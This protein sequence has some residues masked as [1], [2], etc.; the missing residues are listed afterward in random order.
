MQ[1]ARKEELMSL[2]REVLDEVDTALRDAIGGAVGA[3][4]RSN[5]RK[6]AEP[7]R[8]A[9]FHSEMF[10]RLPRWRWA[11]RSWHQMRAR[12][13]RALSNASPVTASLRDSFPAV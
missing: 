5:L 13:F 9:A 1:Q 7:A 2:R 4:E 12:R 3:W 6:Q 8:W 11:A 10:R